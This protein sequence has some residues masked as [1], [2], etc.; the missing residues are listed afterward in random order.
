MFFSCTNDYL[1]Q[2]FDDQPYNHLAE[3][4]LTKL[5]DII[6][7]ELGRQLRATLNFDPVTFC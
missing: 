7:E 4:F 5:S 3:V 2:S 6:V 1:H